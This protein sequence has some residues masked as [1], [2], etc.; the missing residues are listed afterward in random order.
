MNGLLVT[1]NMLYFDLRGEILDIKPEEA[2]NCFVFYLLLII[3]H[4]NGTFSTKNILYVNHHI[5]LSLEKNVFMPL[6]VRA[7]CIVLY[8]I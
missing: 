8:M 2:V 6:K 3:Q 5:Q 1:K 7:L 4:L